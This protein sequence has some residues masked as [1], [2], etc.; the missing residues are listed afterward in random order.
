MSFI[1]LFRIL[2]D[3][4]IKFV[5]NGRHINFKYAV[6]LLESLL[7]SSEEQE[8][9]QQ[10]P[11]TFSNQFLKIMLDLASKVDPATEK[12]ETFP[13]AVRKIFVGKP[14]ILPE[15]VQKLQVS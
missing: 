7:I 5:M 9:K 2:P 13:M 6:A 1:E 14:S 4:H 15:M 10:Y 11:R 3:A 8:F 12:K